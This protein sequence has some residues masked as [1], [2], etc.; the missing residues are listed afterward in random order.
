MTTV[1][2]GP[3]SEQA[4]YELGY[5]NPSLPSHQIKWDHLVFVNAYTCGQ[6]DHHNRATLN[7]K[8]SPDQYNPATFERRTSEDA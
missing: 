2:N 8:Y 6:S 1:M 4:C 5:A 7:P 3:T